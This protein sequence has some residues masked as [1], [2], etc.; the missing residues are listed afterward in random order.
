MSYAFDVAE[1]RGLPLVAAYSWVDA[2]P[3]PE[4]ARWTERPGT[5]AEGRARMDEW[6]DPWAENHPNVTLRR[7]L[8]SQK[9]AC[10]LVELSEQAQLVVVG[11]RGRGP[12]AGLLLGSVSQSL[13]HHAQCPVAVFRAE[14][15]AG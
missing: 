8:T 13:L 15:S 5:E 10:T 7:V 9:P 6:L 3:G 14:P 2:P 1:S 11:A 12:V 4:A